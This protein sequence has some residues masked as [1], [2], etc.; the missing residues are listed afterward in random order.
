MDS[1]RLDPGVRRERAS[2]KTLRHGLSFF[3]ATALIATV[4]YKL[5]GWS[6]IDSLYMVTITVFGVG[7]GEVQPLENP[8]LK[9]FTMGVILAGCSSLIYVLGGFVQLLA[10][11]EIEEMLGT[12]K[13][14][15]EIDQLHDHTIICGY[16]RVGQMLAAELHQKGESFVVLDNCQ[17]RVDKAIG[18][19]FL[20]MVGN[21]VDD[22]TLSEAGLFRAR[23]I[24]TVLPDD[25]ANVFITLTARDLCESICIIARAECPTTER[26]LIRGGATHVVL[27]AA[28][29]AIRIAQ[30]VSNTEISAGQISESRLR[31]LQ[32]TTSSRK[33][34]PCESSVV[35]EPS[36]EDAELIAADVQELAHLA[37]ELS[38][39]MNQRHDEQI[40]G[41]QV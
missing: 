37:S 3:V 31:V 16:G 32:P 14:S 30:L 22:E 40:A 4:G 13:Q 19:G 6:W 11:G 8:L 29:G 25:A 15:R 20:A 23:T 2:H 34:T 41:K 12:R 28:I 5:A 17:S 18:D 26:K 9:L 7:Y 38:Q 36:S 21:A 24:A 35:V 10:E 39:S 33:C 1:T 27:P